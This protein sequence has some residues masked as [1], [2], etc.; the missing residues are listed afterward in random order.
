MLIPSWGRPEIEARIGEGQNLSD[1]LIVFTRVDTE[2]VPYPHDPIIMTLNID[3]YNVQHIL[4][5]SGSSMDILFYDTFL[6]MNIFLN[7]QGE[8][9]PQ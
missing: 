8:W 6:R 4:V 3:G 2:G 7:D 1:E 9:T 5:N